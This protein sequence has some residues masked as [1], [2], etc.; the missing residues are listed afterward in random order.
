[1]IPENISRWIVGDNMSPWWLLLSVA[2]FAYIVYV[3][4]REPKW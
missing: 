3:T 2:G 1:M 4:K